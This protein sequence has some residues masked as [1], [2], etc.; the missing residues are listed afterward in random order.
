MG[1][2]CFTRMET[3][4]HSSFSNKED[5]SRFLK[6][7]SPAFVVCYFTLTGWM[8]WLKAMFRQLFPIANRFSKTTERGD[9]FIFLFLKTCRKVYQPRTP[10]RSEEHTSELQSPC[11]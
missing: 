11:N 2:P 7:R 1:S 9:S 4:G 8:N 6:V 10:T 5:G 3:S